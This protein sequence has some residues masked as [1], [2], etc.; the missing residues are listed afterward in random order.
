MACALTKE[1]IDQTISFHGHWCPGLA[2]GIRACLFMPNFHN[3]MGTL[4]PNENK[5]RLVRLI[6]SHDIP[7]IED[8]ISS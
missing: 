8:D 5:E 3:P 4:M 6:G 2:V 1:Q 7:L